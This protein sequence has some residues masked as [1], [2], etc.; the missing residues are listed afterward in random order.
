MD[1]KIK[2]AEELLRAHAEGFIQRTRSHGERDYRACADRNRF[3]GA[4]TM[5]SI[6]IGE[7]EAREIAD[8]IG[9]ELGETPP[10]GPAEFEI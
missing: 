2:A 3:G 6:L 10:R 7:R 9:R 4:L 5:A 8:R 1:P